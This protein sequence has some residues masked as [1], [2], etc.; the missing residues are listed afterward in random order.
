[1]HFVDVSLGAPA[2]VAPTY[3]VRSLGRD[4]LNH[5]RLLLRRAMMISEPILDAAAITAAMGLTASAG[6]T[7]PSLGGQPT[8]LSHGSPDAVL[9]L[10]L[11]LLVLGLLERAGAY[12]P[13]RSL[14]HIRETAV[15]LT[16]A[17]A[18]MGLL[19]TARLLG[20]TIFSIGQIPVFGAALFALMLLEKSCMHL[21]GQALH[22]RGITPR[23]VVILGAGLACRRMYSAFVNSPRLGM[24]PAMVINPLG[25]K[26]REERVAESSYR[27]KQSAVVLAEQLDCQKL[28][29]AGIE[30]LVLMANN[31][32]SEQTQE[33]LSRAAACGLEAE[34]CIGDDAATDAPVEFTD[35]DGIMVWRPFHTEFEYV[36]KTLKRMIDVGGA[37]VALFMFAPVM[38]AIAAAIK[39]TSP[40]PVFFRQVRV[41]RQGRCFS[42]LKFRS[43]HAHSCGDGFSPTSGSDQRISAVGR[44]LRK[45]SLDEL[46]QLINVLRGEMSMVG[47]RPEMPFIVKGYTPLQFRRLEV[48]PGITGLWQISGHRKHLIHDNMQYDLYYVRHHSFFFDLAILIHTVLFAMKGI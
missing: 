4:G 11:T 13:A 33:I 5:R 22:R 23:P 30:K 29:A 25:T 39:L 45:A 9:L 43:M 28:I 20:I 36:G 3:P 42:M 48:T 40:G 7:M 6:V 26:S 31:F 35:I 21:L 10:P 38:L 44:I 19:L 2:T 16:V 8:W 46:P 47:P 12:R 24:W 15:L 17:S 1:M 34:V 18:V 37:A 41:A 27:V 32:T 14:L